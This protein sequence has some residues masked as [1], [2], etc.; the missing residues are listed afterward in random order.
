MVV[1]VSLH[2]GFRARDVS[3]K[4]CWGDV[5]LQTNPESGKE[6]LVCQRESKTRHGLEGAH[7]RQFNHKV[8][9]TGTERRPNPC[10][11]I[12]ESHR[13]EKAK[14]LSSPFFSGHKPQS[15]HGVRS[16]SGIRLR[17]TR[18]NQI[19]Q[20]LPKAAKNAGLQACG[21]NIANHLV[22]KTSIFRLLD[23]GIPEN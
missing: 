17:A 22:R 9:A 7:Q 13:P 20:F 2:F 8:F 11:K 15:L 3:Q 1:F 18:K 12:F 5:E 6:M 21:R 10:Y 23:A 16:L 14:M 4:L 19:A